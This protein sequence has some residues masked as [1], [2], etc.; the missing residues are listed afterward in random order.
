MCSLATKEH[1]SGIKPKG[2]SDVGKLAPSPTT[3]T[4]KFFIDFFIEENLSEE[5]LK[6]DAEGLNDPH[7]AYSIKV[8]YL[9][10]VS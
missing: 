2:L 10:P 1:L 8:G 6:I 5:N 9:L 4:C 7:S 3:G